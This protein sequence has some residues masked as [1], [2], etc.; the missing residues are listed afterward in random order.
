MMRQTRFAKLTECKVSLNSLLEHGRREQDDTH[1]KEEHVVF[2]LGVGVDFKVPGLGRFNSVVEKR[3]WL[4][5][6]K[7]LARSLPWL[8]IL[9]SVVQLTVF[10]SISDDTSYDLLLPNSHH[11]VHDA[12]YAARTAGRDLP[13]VPQVVKTSTDASP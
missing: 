13:E 9:I 8:I 4:D 12:G 3:S 11:D 5:C 1:D 2:D 6:F 7:N 10:Y